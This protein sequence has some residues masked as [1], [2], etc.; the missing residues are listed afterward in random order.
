MVDAASQGSEKPVES[1][2]KGNQVK[3]TPARKSSPP[4][5]P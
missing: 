5:K 3:P 1:M 4:R 2:A